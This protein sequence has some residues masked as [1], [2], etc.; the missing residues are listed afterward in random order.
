[1]IF[2]NLKNDKEHF[3]MKYQ[4]LLLNLDIKIMFAS[5]YNRI[6]FLIFKLLNKLSEF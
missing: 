5:H 1:M 3:D 4:F 6:Y 2:V